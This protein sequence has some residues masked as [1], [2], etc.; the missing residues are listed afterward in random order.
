[1][2]WFLTELNNILK[3]KQPSKQFTANESIFLEGDKIDGVFYIKKGK[4]KVTKNAKNNIA[5]WFANENEFV[6]LSSFFN[7]SESY[8]FS[9]YAFAGDVDA[10]FISTDEF[11]DMLN[12]Y[13][14]F[15]QE[16]IQV[17]CDRITSTR[18]RISN[19]KTQSIKQR[20]LDTILFL[21]DLKDLNK[22][23]VTIQYTIDELSELTGTSKQYI[24]KLLKE[25]HQ[26][27]LIDKLKDNFMVIN[28]DR[29]QLS[30]N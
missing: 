14:E 1:M 25:F 13:P 22:T 24:Q 2:D 29:L 10:V 17:L 20:F 18:K 5:V 26:K 28:V 30:I 6:G 21:I 27:K 4:V 9:T 19:I 15:K 23:K 11:R 3:S 16:I 7:D 12:N 8:S